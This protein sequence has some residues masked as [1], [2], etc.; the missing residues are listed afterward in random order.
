MAAA[1][2]HMAGTSWPY[3]EA[4]APAGLPG[5][6]PG[7][8][9]TSD[10]GSAFGAGGPG[11]LSV[12]GTVIHSPPDAVAP[13]AMYGP[14]TPEQQAAHD[15]SVEAFNVA[16]GKVALYNQ[17]VHDVQLE[18][19]TFT[20]WVDANVTATVD[21][22]DAPAVDKLLSVVT[23]NLANFTV[24]FSTE[25]GQRLLKNIS[26]SLNDKASD[27]RSARRSGNPARRALG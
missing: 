22:F 15:R 14:V 4:G 9:F 25:A 13:P 3:G 17:L 26:T 10:P 1:F 7:N 23:D 8:P 27:L 21:T 16:A 24:G 12:T 20:D 5:G 11:G 6:Q 2:G 19:V 18:E